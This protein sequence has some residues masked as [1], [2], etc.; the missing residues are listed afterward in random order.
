[1]TKIRAKILAYT[2]KEMNEI[3]GGPVNSRRSK[4]KKGKKFCVVT[5]TAILDREKIN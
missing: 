5:G 4:R 3:G 1:V 2:L